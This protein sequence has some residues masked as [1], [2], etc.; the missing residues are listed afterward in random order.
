MKTANTGFPHH[1][2]VAR[3]TWAIYSAFTM[4]GST[5]VAVYMLLPCLSRAYFHSLWWMLIQ[6]R[7]YKQ[8]R[9]HCSSDYLNLP[10]VSISL[11]FHHNTGK[12]QDVII[13][14]LM[15]FP[16]F[17]VTWPSC[18]QHII[19]LILFHRFQGV[20][21][22]RLLRCLSLATYLCCQTQSVTGGIQKHLNA[23]VLT[24]Y[25]YTQGYL[26]FSLLFSPA[27]FS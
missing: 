10:G 1:R 24:W 22:A 23:I 15:P 4:K 25:P 20:Q 6:P 16:Y 21:F 14:T 12:G 9:L 11:S 3:R 27:A 26:F 5:S 8:V 2:A 17:M 18:V 13:I 19:L 7:D